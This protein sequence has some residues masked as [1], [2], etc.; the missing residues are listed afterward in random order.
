MKS[1]RSVLQIFLLTG[2]VFFAGMDSPVAQQFSTTQDLLMV[3]TNHR[4]I[5]H[6]VKLMSIGDRAQVVLELPGLTETVLVNVYRYRIDHVT[7][8]FVYFKSRDCSGSV[9]LSASASENNVVPATAIAGENQSL[10]IS[11]GNASVM[12][13]VGSML[14]G[15][16]CVTVTMDIEALNA[17]LIADLGLEYLPPYTVE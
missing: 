16:D 9:Y 2:V 6:V 14:S 1:F 3:D 5:G 17:E 11:D 13:T 7:H 8:P 4:V 10:Y 12:R 15:R